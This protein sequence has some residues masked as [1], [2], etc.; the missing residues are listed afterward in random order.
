MNARR[1]FTLVEVLLVLGLV[2]IV[3]G[4]SVPLYREFQIRNDLNLAMEQTVQG[5]RRAQILS[6]AAQNDDEWGFYVPA[7]TLYKGRSYETRNVAYD[8]VYPMPSNIGT[9]GLTEVSYT[10]TT[11]RA[12]G[13]GTITL[14]ATNDETRSIVVEVISEGVVTTLNDK[15]LICHHP[16]GNPEN[17]NTL[18]VADSAWP[19][20]ESHG[21]TLGA[22]PGDP[23]P[24][25][26][27]SSS[28]S[29]ASSV[30][31]AQSSVGG[32][33]SGGS[34]SA[35]GGGGSCE[36]RF[37]VSSNGAIETTG[38]VNME[39]QVL[40]SQITY[41]SGGPEVDVYV[42]YSKDGGKKYTNLF[43]GNDVDGG[44]QATITGLA[45]GTKI[46]I[47]ARGYFRKRGW[48]TFD[49]SYTTIDGTTHL[50]PLRN[51]D[52]VPNFPAFGDQSGLEVFLDNVIDAQNNISIA[53]Y[54]VVILGELGVSNLSQP[55]AAADFQDIVLLLKF[56]QQP[57]SCS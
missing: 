26:E 49:K 48:L 20:H 43:G 39:V 29:A 27:S 37:S 5:L 24:D 35:G 36:D 1:G 22:C 34:S 53:Q 17:T 21:D 30:S 40:G 47:K 9:T 52:P 12:N 7:G 19:S 10:K 4:I 6:Q 8:E 2:S 42:S 28:S 31:S 54:D 14:H 46:A 44:E 56:T 57:G 45:S 18:S 23:D 33:S 38:L 50:R 11:G 16:P 32:A 25:P 51:G 13:T 55:S 41:G 15:F 3:G